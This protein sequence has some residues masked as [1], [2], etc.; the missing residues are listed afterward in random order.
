MPLKT[1]EVIGH[2]IEVKIVKNVYL[3]ENERK[4]KSRNTE[5]FRPFFS[6]ISAAKIRC[7]FSSVINYYSSN[8][9]TRLS[10]HMKY[11]CEPCLSFR[12]TYIQRYFV[13]RIHWLNNRVHSISGVPIFYCV[14]NY[15]EKEI[16]FLLFWTSLHEGHH[17]SGAVLYFLCL[18]HFSLEVST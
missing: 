14:T 6:L 9:A 10:M 11:E 7:F 13:P 16:L 15:Q 18:V 12:S 1:D 8:C 2:Q 17:I 3:K 5:T 4:K